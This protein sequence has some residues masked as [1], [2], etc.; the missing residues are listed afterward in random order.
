MV[1]ISACFSGVFIPALAGPD[2]L[3]LTA[4][5]RDRSSFGC[6]EADTYPFF[7]GCILDALARAGDFLAAGGEARACVARREREEHMSPPSQPQVYVGAR[8]H[9]LPFATSR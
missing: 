7:D 9:A 6:G 3:I 2:R 8:F 4:A 1:V 5:R